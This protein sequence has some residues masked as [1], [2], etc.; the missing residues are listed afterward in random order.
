[1]VFYVLT[2]T[3]YQKLVALL[4]RPP[5]PVWLNEGVLSDAEIA[6]L[7]SSG[8]NV[9]VFSGQKSPDD[10]QAIT[11]NIWIIQEHHDGKSVWV[12]YPPSA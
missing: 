12:Q 4:G 3:E 5:S 2:T 7:R 8:H 10:F 9:T 11:K 6:E 1:M